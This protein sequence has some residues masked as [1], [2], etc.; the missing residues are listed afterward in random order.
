M[1]CHGY[2]L[3]T[4][5]YSSHLKN[6]QVIY[7]LCTVFKWL[8]TFYVYAIFTVMYGFVSHLQ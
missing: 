2:D 4:E 3:E 8:Y 1:H 5:K 6:I 7:T